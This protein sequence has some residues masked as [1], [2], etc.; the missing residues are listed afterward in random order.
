MRFQV[1]LPLAEWVMGGCE[2]G[3]GGSDGVQKGMMLHGKC[4]MS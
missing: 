3:A 2:E 1:K 4:W